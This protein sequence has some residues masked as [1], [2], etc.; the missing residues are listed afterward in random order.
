[1]YGPLSIYK[2]FWLR[3]LEILENS[4]SCCIGR[5]PT[6]MQLGAFHVCLGSM[7]PARNVLRNFKANDRTF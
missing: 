3:V 5:R 1:M 4:I 6:H 7:H 2:D